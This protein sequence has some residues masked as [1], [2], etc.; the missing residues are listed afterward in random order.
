MSYI[1]SQMTRIAKG[2][3]WHR[4]FDAGQRTKAIEITMKVA[5]D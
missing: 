2:S 5:H 4:S 3:K 1:Q